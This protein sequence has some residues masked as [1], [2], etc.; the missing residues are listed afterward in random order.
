M[1][2]IVGF[3]GRF[4]VDL[5]AKMTEAVAHRGPNGQGAVAYSLDSQPLTGLGHR[6]LA[7]I[8]LSEAGHQPMTVRPDSGGGMRE[9]LTLVFNG[10]IYNHREL[11]AELEG[12]GHVFQSNSDSEVLLHLYERDGL[13]MLPRLNGIFAF[14][15]HDARREGRPNGVDR[16]ALF[17]ARDQIGVKP[18]YYASTDRGILFGSE[19]KALLCDDS[20]SRDVD[21]VAVHQTLAYL[22]TP[23]PATMLSSVRKLPPGFAA[24]ISGGRMVR[25]WCHYDIPY[26]GTRS[27]ASRADTA[28][29]LRE[30][31]AQAVRRQLVS[32]V[33]VGAYLSGGLDSSAN[34]VMAG[35]GPAMTNLSHLTPPLPLLRGCSAPGAAL[36][37]A[38][39]SVP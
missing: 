6:R 22:W 2:G 11:R 15:I 3:Q 38:C 14:A 20:L 35:S 37:S 5:L 1:C 19:I 31:L 4:S 7:I 33:P 21:P 10:E 32:D 9:G 13:K 23:A 12:V 36:P 8:D 18:F 16:G 25:H 34:P 29:A 28:E 39:A 27:D 24:I 30:H 26:D 17:V